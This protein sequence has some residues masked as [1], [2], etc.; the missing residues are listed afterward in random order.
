MIG[1]FPDGRGTLRYVTLKDASPG[2][3]IIRV[4]FLDEVSR[5]LHSKHL[6]KPGLISILKSMR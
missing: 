2:A 5:T 1:D 4:R 3:A 6:Q